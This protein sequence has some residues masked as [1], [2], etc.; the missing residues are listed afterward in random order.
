MMA[1]V[2]EMETPPL[3]SGEWSEDEMCSQRAASEGLP[4]FLKLLI[5]LFKL[6]AHASAQF[7][8]RHW[9]HS[10]F[11]GERMFGGTYAAGKSSAA[12][13]EELEHVVFH[14]PRLAAR[15]VALK[16]TVEE[17]TGAAIREQQVF[18]DLLCGP[19]RPLA[20]QRPDGAE[21]TGVTI[22]SAKGFA[23]A[24]VEVF[25]YGMHDLPDASGQ[26]F[27][28]AENCT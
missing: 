26:E 14:L 25:Q 3:V 15:R 27:P 1:S 20:P 24:I 9:C 23:V 18:Y 12:D 11:A 28:I 16:V 21:L 6:R 7:F 10:R 19:G 2:D 17:R 8:S 13:D 5:H 4:A 22:F